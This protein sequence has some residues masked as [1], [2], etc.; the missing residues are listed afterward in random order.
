MAVI[1]LKFNQELGNAAAALNVESLLDQINMASGLWSLDW[2]N[3]FFP[4]P[5]WK[6]NKNSLHSQGIDKIHTYGFVWCYFNSTTLC[7]DCWIGHEYQG[8][9][10]KIVLVH[11]IE[12]IFFFLTEQGDKEVTSFLE[13]LV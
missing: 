11:Y 4:I 7:R 9:T 2:A 5:M 12:N 8:I 10:H 13:A 3:V 1:Y 6:K